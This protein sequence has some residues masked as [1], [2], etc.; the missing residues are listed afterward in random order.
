MSWTVDEVRVP[1]TL[2]QPGAEDFIELVT[3]RNHIEAEILGSDALSWTPAG[4]IPIFGDSAHRLRRHFVVRVDGRMVG[5][6]LVGWPA[7]SDSAEAS[8]YVEVLEPYRRRGIGEALLAQAEALTA[9]IG[10]PVLQSELPHTPITGGVRV[11]S[12]TGFGDVSAEDPG[13]RFLQ[14]HGFQLEMVAR[15]SQLDLATA[16]ATVAEQRQLAEAHAGADYRV[17]TWAGPAPTDRYED[18]AKLKTA[19]STDAPSAGMEMTVDV[20]DLERVADWDVRMQATGRLLF[21]A[22]AEHVPSGQLVAYS[23]I[24]LPRGDAQPATQEDTLVL[25]AHRGHRLGL[26]TKAAN[27]QH[28]VAAAPRTT[29]ITTFNA[30]DNVPMLAVNVALGFQPIGI[31]GNWQ[32]DLR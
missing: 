4:L 19:M 7:S 15:I 3:L 18:L 26:L 30:E 32:K 16:A 13:V 11:P 29:V 28:L 12:P 21:T 31:E 25:K 8:I 27:I 9:W 6:A 17:V 10:R 14:Q 2:D 24:G 22:A 20:W 1:A 5:R 23:E